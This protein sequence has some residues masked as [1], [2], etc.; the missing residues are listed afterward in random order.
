MRHNW[1]HT[2]DFRLLD[3]INCIG[4]QLAGNELGVTNARR[5]GW[6]EGGFVLQHSGQA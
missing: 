6:G 4:G 5:G 1:L 3:G 2:P